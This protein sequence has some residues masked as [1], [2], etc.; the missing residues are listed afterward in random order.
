MLIVA[1]LE[2]EERDQCPYEPLGTDG[3]TAGS[4]T[5]AGLSVASVIISGVILSS[6]AIVAAVAVVVFLEVHRFCIV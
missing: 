2:V 4:Y 1:W 6:V 3:V 5:R